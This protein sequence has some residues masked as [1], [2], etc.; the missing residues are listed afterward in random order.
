MKKTALL[1]VTLLLAAVVAAQNPTAYFMEGSTFRSQFNPAFAPL[2]GYVNIPGAGGIQV[3]T[4]GNLAVS[5][6]LY[7]RGGSLV[8]LLDNTVSAAEALGNLRERNLLGTDARVNLIGFGAFTRNRKNFWSFDLNLRVNQDASLP[9]SLFEFLKKG[10]S[11]DIRDVSVGVDSYLEAGF[12]YS[13]PLL[14][15][16]LYIGVRG[17]FLVG[18]ARAELRYDHLKATLDENVWRVDATGVL[19]VTAAGTTVET[20]LNDRGEETY[21]PND[22]DFEPK[23][24]AGYGF[25]VDLGATYDILPNLQ[26]SLAVND[27]GFISWS[28]KHNVSGR[29]A[30]ELTFEGVQV[31]EYGTSTQPEF[32]LDILE[33]TPIEARS[34]SKM[35][36]AS[37][38][39][40]LEYELWRHKIG[41]GLLYS[42]RFWEYKTLHNITGSVNFHPV[43]WLTLTGSYTV[44]D[45]RGG[46]VGLALNLHPGW[47]N[48]FIATDLLTTKHTPQWVPVDKSSMNVTLGLGIPVG[49]RSHRIAAYIRP[50]DR[51]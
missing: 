37:L 47:I 50:G 3:G 19:D 36:R 9:Y 43:R 13:F 8:T 15:D 16:K 42:A 45:T 20:S 26:A 4:G 41:I 12:N 11:T 10:S 24:P 39:A 29:S 40:G 27:L 46:A 34:H 25:A 1:I 23:K 21:K 17:K 14:N 2:R 33:F 35:L 31:D 51:R 28:G 38:H 30:K 32:D 7:P 49:K 44:I 6:I 5:D 48:F 18:A 22:L